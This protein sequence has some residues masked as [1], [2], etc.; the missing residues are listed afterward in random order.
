MAK[1]VVIV[2]VGQLG[3]RYLEGLLQS[4]SEMNIWLVDSD[5]GAL[6]QAQE[7]VFEKKSSL[8]RRIE[9]SDSIRDLPQ[10]LD[11]VIS[12]TTANA[13]VSTLRQLIDGRSIGV[14]LLE[15]MLSQSLSESQELTELAR[16]CERVWVNYPRRIMSWHSFLGDFVQR[17]APVRGSV[18][19]ASWGLVTNSLHFIDLFEWWTGARAEEVRIRGRSLRWVESKRPGFLDATGTVDVILG[20]GSH[21]TLQSDPAEN[22]PRATQIDLVGQHKNLVISETKGVA[23][24]TMVGKPMFGRLELQSHLTGPLVDQIFANGTCSLPTLEDVIGTHDLFIRVLLDDWARNHDAEA[25]LM[26]T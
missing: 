22:Q 15:K 12:A 6:G 10:R 7:T 1:D 5:P 23:S 11:L 16:R 25:R 4:T 8:P 13:R 21:L 9:F 17:N 26:V 3:R 14:V 19:G 24:G 2:G 18:V 20:D